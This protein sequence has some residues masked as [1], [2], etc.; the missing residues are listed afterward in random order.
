LVASYIA[1]KEWWACATPAPTARAAARR[2]ENLKR[3]EVLAAM[4]LAV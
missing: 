4:E 1:E 3:M 2:T